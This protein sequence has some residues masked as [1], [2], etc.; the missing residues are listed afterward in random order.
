MEEIKKSWEHYNQARDNLMTSAL[1][2]LFLPQSDRTIPPQENEKSL[3][4]LTIHN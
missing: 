2:A 4:E 3:G 1:L